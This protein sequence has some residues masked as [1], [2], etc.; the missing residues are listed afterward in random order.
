MER[1]NSLRAILGN[2]SQTFDS[3]PLYPSN[4]ERAAHLLYF[5]IKDHPFSDGNKR[6]GAFLFLMFLNLS[7]I[8]TLEISNS[9]ITALTLLI[10]ESDPKQK[11]I[12]IKL[13]MKMLVTE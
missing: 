9:C 2:L 4:L 10:A 7:K 3:M 11:E 6:V 8:N 13:V 5:V 1:E 12:M